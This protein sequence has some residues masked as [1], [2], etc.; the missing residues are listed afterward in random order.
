MSFLTRWEEQK[1]QILSNS[2]NHEIF[3]KCE[4]LEEFKNTDKAKSVDETSSRTALLRSLLRRNKTFRSE[5]AKELDMDHLYLSFS[6]YL[7]AFTFIGPCANILKL[8]GEIYLRARRFLVK[9]GIIQVK[10]V[11]IESLIAT[12]CL[13]Q[14]Q[15]IH[16]SVKSKQE[17]HNRVAAFFFPDFPYVDNNS[18][19]QVADLFAVDIDLTTRKFIKAK[20]DQIDLTASETLILLW[21]NTI[22]AQHVKLHSFGNWGV[23]FDASIGQLNPLFYRSSIVTA[24]YNHFG[25]TSFRGFMG[26]WSKQGILSSNWDPQ[27]MVDCIDHGVKQNVSQHSQIRDLIPHSRFVRFAVKVRSIFFAEFAKHKHLFPGVH[28]EA[29]FVGTILHSLDHT[30]MEWNLKD[31]LWLDVNDPRF[32][33]MAELG[34]IVRTGFVEDVPG[35]YFHKRFKGSG[36]PFY[37]AVYK[38]AAKIDKDLA[39]N[40]DACIIK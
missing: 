38:K 14:S 12:L 1:E 36:H 10:P 2:S 35:L 4:L 25:Y 30:L 29:M 26:K 20:M 23:N 39:D 34:Q 28:A 40:M 19:Y 8:K 18:K 22:F 5:K 3:S 16:Y 24:I 15:V 17:N 31:P 13:E 21:F 7:W 33:K 37:E 27:A 32:G 6:Q 11:V 9:H